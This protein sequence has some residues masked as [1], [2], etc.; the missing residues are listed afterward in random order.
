MSRDCKTEGIEAMRS[1]HQGT[2]KLHTKTPER[3]QKRKQVFSVVKAYQCRTKWHKLRSW[4]PRDRWQMGPT[5]W[6]QELDFDIT[7]LLRRA[8]NSFRLWEAIC[9]E[10]QADLE[11]LAWAILRETL[12]TLM[13]IEFENATNMTSS[14]MTS[15]YMT[16]IRWDTVV[17]G[18][19]PWP[20]FGWGQSFL[21]R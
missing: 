19:P 15:S 18:S 9:Y 6:L 14:Y 11:T 8:W 5:Q 10:S 21:L 4:I 20:R 7:Q 17:P 3:S 12:G 2:R 16:W 13:S 1:P